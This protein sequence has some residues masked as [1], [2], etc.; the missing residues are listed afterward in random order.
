MEWE[1]RFRGW[2]QPG[3]GVAYYVARI[4]YKT[5]RIDAVCVQYAVVATNRFS[6]FDYRTKTINYLLLAMCVRTSREYRVQGLFVLSVEV[7]CG[8]QEGRLGI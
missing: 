3:L 8:L 4:G 1:V 5:A 6:A 2:P 7:M